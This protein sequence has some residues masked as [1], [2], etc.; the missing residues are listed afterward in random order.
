MDPQDFP[1]TTDDLDN[2]V[3]TESEE[4]EVRISLTYKNTIDK[5]KEPEE[6]LESKGPLESPELL[7]IPE[8][9]AV[10]DAR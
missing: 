10:M 6:S 9:P 3:T 2:A 1:D 8:F 4:N 7:E 5:L